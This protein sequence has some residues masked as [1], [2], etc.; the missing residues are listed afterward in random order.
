[1]PGSETP[2]DAAVVDDPEPA[3]GPGPRGR[4]M[5]HLGGRETLQRLADLLA[6]KIDPTR[7]TPRRVLYLHLSQNSYRRDGNGVARFEG[8][9][10]VTLEQLR[11]LFIGARVTLKPVIDLEQQRAVERYA[12]P[13]DLAEAVQLVSCRSLFP[14]SPTSSRA[15]AIDMEHAA[16]FDPGLVGGGDPQTSLANVGP[17]DR[18]SHRVKTHQPGWTMRQPR[19]GTRYW[20][21]R[22]GYCYR[23]DGS[24]THALGRHS[25]EAFHLGVDA[26]EAAHAH[27]SWLDPLAVIALMRDIGASPAA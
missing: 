20:R 26:D 15:D 10:P 7:L 11:D 4:W 8:E 14:W 5:A 27:G 2:T 19:P 22:Y 18:A 1:V 24:G 17:L 6:R 21:T 16:A 9:Q 25:L 3:P 23:V 12:V 13:A